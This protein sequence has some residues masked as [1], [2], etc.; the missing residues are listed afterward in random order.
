M[1]DTEIKIICITLILAMGVITVYPVLSSR[2]IIEPSSEIGVLGPD[3]K[4]GDYPN[5]IK[6]GDS[7]NLF[8]YVGNNEGRVQYYR[9]IVQLLPNTAINKSNNTQ[10]VNVQTIDFFDVFLMNG[11]NKIIPINFTL[12]QPSNNTRLAFE[13]Y[14]YNSGTQ[15]FVYKNS[16][17]LWLTVT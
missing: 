3:G 8:I 13:L 9:I 17:N 5:N 14:T 12:N 2:I 10:I 7:L 15:T 1:I 4:I 11:Q 16:A 6:A